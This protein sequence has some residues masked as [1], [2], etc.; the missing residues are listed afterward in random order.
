MPHEANALA[1]AARRGLDEHGIADIARRREEGGIRLLLTHV[2]RHDRHARARHEQLR[3]AL[4]AHARDDVWRGADEGEAGR[5]TGGSELGVLSQKAI[6]GMNRVGTGPAGSLG[7]GG[8]G[9]I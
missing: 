2:A 5:A 3:L 7:P 4:A 8:E 9:E 6:A 1:A